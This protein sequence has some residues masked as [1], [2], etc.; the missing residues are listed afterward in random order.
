LHFPAYQLCKLLAYLFTHHGADDI[1]STVKVLAAM[2][3]M[4]L[5]WL[6]AAIVVYLYFGWEAAALSVPAAFI[7]G[8]AALYSLEEFEELRG[9]T[10]AVW[11]FLTDRDAFLRLFVERRNLQAELKDLQTGRPDGA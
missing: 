9:W 4:P 6:A 7:C 2:L 11:V 3:F 1:V 8:Y 5:T 10:K